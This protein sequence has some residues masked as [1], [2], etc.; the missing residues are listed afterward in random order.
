MTAPILN[1]RDLALQ[2]A[3][4]RSK[5]TNLAITGTASAFLASKNSVTILPQTI[6]LTATPSGSVFSSNAMY[7]WSYALSSAPNTWITLGTGK[8]WTLNNTD[9]WVKNASVQY[10]CIISE[11][12]LDS[13]YGYYTVTYSSEGS[14]SN[15]I[16]ISRTNVVVPCSATGVPTSFNNTDI[17][18]A[19]SRG[20]TDLAYSTNSTTPNSFTVSI[21]DDGNLTRNLV[22]TY[23]STSTSFTMSGIS[24]LAFDGATITFTINVYDSSAT[25]VAT[26]YTRKVVYNKVSNGVAGSSARAVDLTIGTQAFAYLSDGT[27]PSPANTVITATAQNTT[28]TVY[29]EFFVAGVSKQN[30]TTNTYTYTPLAAYAS[31]PEQII[32]KLREGSNNSTILASD[33]ASI[34]GIKPGVDS[35]I[36]NLTNPSATVIADSSGGISSGTVASG[37]FKIYNGIV[38]KTGDA[39]VTYSVYSYTTGLTISIASTGIYSVTGLSV[40]SG[41]AI[42]RAIYGGVTIDLSF[43]I[44]KSKA[45]VIGASARAV[46]L[47]IGTQAFAYLSDGSTPSPANTVITA[48]AQNTTGT[49]YYEFFVAGVSKQNTTTNTYTYTPL[50]AYASM[51]QQITVK[52]REGTNSS[53]ILASDI[54]SI[55]ATKP[56]VDSIVGNLSNPTSTVIGDV[57]GNVSSFANTSGTFYVYD[58]ITNKTGDA[59]VTYSVLSY[60]GLTISIASTGVYTVSAMDKDVIISTAILRAVYK[61]VT[62][63]LQYT[64][65]K[66]K[67]SA[68]GSNINPLVNYDFAGATLLSNV[69][70]PGTVATYETDTATLLTNTVTDQNLRLTNLDLVPNNSYII[71]MRVKWVS[72]AWEGLLFYANPSHGE[73][74]SHFKLIPQPALDVWTT[75]NIDMR[76][77]TA[78]GTEYLTG[79]NITQLR[80]DFINAVSASVAVDY[81]S[82][83]KYGI[84]EGKKSITLSMYYWATSPPAYSGAFTYNWNTGAVSAY[85]TGWSSAAGTAPGNGYTL[86]QRNITLT[87]T[88]LAAT[89]N[90]NWSGSSVNTIG[91]RNDGTIGV[92]GDSYRIA[93][94]VTTSGT[95]PSTPGAT[96]VVPPATT[97]IP[98]GWSAT[99]T[100]N[101]T[102]GQYMYQSDGV[103]SSNTNIIT[104]GIPY[105]SNLKVGSLSALSANL[106]VV[107]IAT[108]GNL[109]SGKS[110][111]GSAAA[112]FFLGNDSGNAKFRIGTAVDPITNESNELAFN[113]QTGVLTLRGG[114]VFNAAGAALLSGT[115]VPGDINNSAIVIGGAN[116]MRNS[117]NFSSATGWAS[118]GSTVTYSS[119]VPYGSYGTLQLVGTG[120]AVNNVVMRLKANTQYTVSAF[121]KGSA[122]LA[123]GYDNTLHIQSWR[124]EDTGNLHQETSVAYDTAITTSW[125]RIYQT[126]TTPSSA[127]LTYCRFYF[128]PL[129]AGFTLNVG[130]VK[131]EEG[132]F[133]TDWV[134][135][136]E[137][138]AALVESARSS[139]VSTAA[140]DA[141]TKANAAQTAAVAAATA[142]A[143]TD[144]QTRAT[145]AQTA[146]VAAA[147]SDA[148]T[149]ATAAQTAAISVANTAQAAAVTAQAAAVAAQKAAD[150]AAAAANVLNYDPT[151]SDPAIWP[152]ANIATISG[153]LSGTTAIVGST[154]EH[155]AE[156]KQFIVDRTRRYRVTA[157][158]RKTAGATSGTVYLGLLNYDI[159]GTQQYTWGGYTNAAWSVAS[160]LTTSFQTF[161]S[162]FAPNALR[163]GT[164]KAA[165]HII[166]GYSSTGGG[167]VE[168]QNVRVTDITEAY[169]AQV[170]ADTAAANAATAQSTANSATAS[171]ATAISNAATAQARANDAYDNAAAAAAAA[172]TKLSKSANDTLSGKIGFN[173]DGAIV[174]G[175]INANTGLPD[176]GIFIGPTGI[177][178][179]KTVSGTPTNR[180]FLSSSGDATFAGAIEGATFSTSSGRFSVDS[181]GYMS[182]TE[183]SFNGYITAQSFTTIGGKFTAQSNGTVIA[184]LVDIRKRVVLEYGTVDPVEVI[185]G[186]SS[187]SDA[188]VVTYYPA[189]T[190]FRGQINQVVYTVNL[191]PDLTTYDSS[192]NQPYYVAAYFNGSIRSWTGS[193]GSTYDF[194]LRAHAM[195]V[196]TYSNSGTYSNN[197]R[198]SMIF[199]YA[200]VLTSGT[201]TSFRLPTATWI[202]YRL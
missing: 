120:G 85:P 129:A 148:S 144:A 13:A 96:T 87:D 35:I 162:D 165:A 7:T 2:A 39:T 194:F 23:T 20:T 80:F 65:D 26:T 46:N 86:Y 164:V 193:S 131:L 159:N 48:T 112:G 98:S 118:N 121:V 67:P 90:A 10:R 191:P 201:F 114:N 190:V 79:G 21:A 30:T 142:A 154:G 29:Y 5:Q 106:G 15:F 59:A 83:G 145:A 160:S 81:I 124:D 196:R 149:K 174:V 125:K 115:T 52:I 53:T 100:A 192:G 22:G 91:Y 82:I 101:L 44:A 119:L 155:I 176:N 72:G 188:K 133:P 49:P 70:F 202:I 14:E 8:T 42:L 137:D 71:S 16:T 172:S 183:G 27:T 76:S 104:W 75:I 186:I 68:D 170:A 128:Y 18:I 45:G 138:A 54:M 195:P 88:T 3:K 177:V 51:P 58:G 153:G 110:T 140:S 97:A 116:L 9:T 158:I 189:G 12:L 55:I 179:R 108:E 132:N 102:D 167:R 184:D 163:E 113:S 50:A 43:T 95:A 147:A 175:V 73:S 150:T 178:A 47:T 24:A 135:N 4:Y 62:I 77:L 122:A 89:T 130:Y 56:G 28:G 180:F 25:P 139:A 143:A 41:A 123:T 57:Y 60:T 19:V 38:D 105:L 74:G 141:T 171:A 84:A 66:S 134:I 151:C 182:A 69:T 61:G 117:G 168:F 36:G 37:T 111:F 40:D 31:M 1:D 34:I 33:I 169:A 136:V 187:P 126:F 78:G 94:I 99:A 198:V 32:V 93:Y 17:T 152:A 109:Y 6:V 185:S 161:T 156:S 197:G 181:N 157:Y 146:A 107:N 63:D 103:L 173:P 200:M 11:N 127:N 64:M 92:Q 199:D 166:L